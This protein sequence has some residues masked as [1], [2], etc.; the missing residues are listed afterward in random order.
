MIK[1]FTNFHYATELLDVVKLFYAQV[2]QVTEQTSADITVTETING[3]V[4]H[5]VCNYCQIVCT[6]QFDLTSNELVNTRY[7]KRHAKI[8]L[9]NALVKATGKTMPWGSLTGIRPTK[10][11][12]QLTKEGLIWQD[13]FTDV[14]GVS[15]EKVLL[16]ADI[17]KQQGNLATP[18]QNSADLYIGIPFCVSRCSYCSFTSGE[19]Q[20]LQKYVEPYVDA[21]CNDIKQTI[22][23]ASQRNIRLTNV[24]FGGG[25]PT[26]LTAEQLDK[27]MDCVTFNPCEYTVEAGRPDTITADKLDVLKRHGVHRLSINPQTFNQSVLDTVGRKHSV[28]DIYDKFQM[29]LSYGFIV[30]MDLIAGLPSET[31]DMF[32]YSINE[33][34]RLAP[35]NITVHTLALKHGSILKE[36]NYSNQENDVKQMV[37]YAHKQLYKAGYLPY[38]MYRQKYMSDNLE[39]VGFCKPDTVCAYNVGIMEEVTNIMACG[40]GA[41]SKRIFSAEDRIERAANAKD[42]ITYVNRTQD[43]ID[44]KLE[45]FTK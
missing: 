16:V 18:S 23:F 4:A 14:L 44:K 42:V 21:L 10:L 31:V 45:L 27:V 5:Y 9:Y 20:R 32:R 35:H 12:R 8:A 39:N 1:L 33:A 41:I 24:Y 6:S 36:A 40:T 2:E 22:Q 7:A 15:Q 11:A 37:E 25:T 29:A 30:N 28:E 43:Y 26:S 19:I 13:T 38:Y 17:L 34:I 3:N